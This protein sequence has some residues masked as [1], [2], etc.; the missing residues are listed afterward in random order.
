MSSIDHN[1]GLVISILLPDLKGG[2]AERVCLNL[3]N[4]FVERGFLVDIVLMQAKGDLLPLLDRRVNVVDLEVGRMRH[5]AAPL[6]RYLRQN[7]PASILVNMWPMTLLAWVARWKAGSQARLVLAEHTTWSI[8]P[9]WH[10]PLSRWLIKIS[11]R[12]VYPHSDGVVTVSHGAARELE[13][14]AGLPDGGVRMIY[15]PIVDPGRARSCVLYL[16]A[17]WLEG[18]HKRVLTVGAL[19]AIKDYSTLIS[20]FAELSRRLDAKLLI[21]GEGE[22]R[23]AIA[24]QVKQLG[25]QGRVLMPGFTA[26]PR[27]YYQRA[28]IF[29]LSSRGEGFGNVIVEALEQGTPVV[30]TDCPS[31]PREI[32]ADGKYGT[33]VPVGDIEAL[34][35]AMEASLAREHDREAL[36]QRAQDFSV[37]K[38]ADAYL[39][40]LAPDWREHATS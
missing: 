19:K 12:L 24:H 10:R 14:I 5:L 11:M 23:V 30:S 6:A 36:K 20:S 33:L 9:L 37:A 39:D 38:S 15:N 7:R 28:D 25:L 21:L 4:N 18:P 16:A 17:E 35:S 34:A 27:P 29:V 22:E 13:A 1:R 3:A 32:L 8:D 40:L 26:D 31:G 2:G